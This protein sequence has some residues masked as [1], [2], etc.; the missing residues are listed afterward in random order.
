MRQKLQKNLLQ[1]NQRRCD[2]ERRA[3]RRAPDGWR[4]PASPLPS[5]GAR[6]GSTKTIGAKKLTPETLSS[7]HTHPAPHRRAPSF[8]AVPT[9]S[10]QSQPAEE[11]PTPHLPPSPDLDRTPRAPARKRTAHLAH[12]GSAVTLRPAHAHTPLR[13][14]THPNLKTGSLRPTNHPHST[15]NKRPVH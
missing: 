4:H 14:A 11:R 12:H 13:T 7:S 3:A 2:G 10:H 9:S 6:D 15:P 5:S 1:A 8:S